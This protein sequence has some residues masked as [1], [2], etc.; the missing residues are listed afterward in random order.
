M[1][2]AFQRAL[3]RYDLA[4]RWD[5]VRSARLYE[6]KG[7][8]FLRPHELSEID[9]E[10]GSRLHNMVA[11]ET[12]YAV[13]SASLRA[14]SRLVRSRPGDIF[15]ELG[16]SFAMYKAFP[17]TLMH[18]HLMRG[19]NE[20]AKN[21]WTGSGY[22]AALMIST[23]LMGA[24]AMNLKEI[25]K[26]RDPRDMSDPKAWAA[27]AMQGGGLGIWGDFFFADA[28]RYGQGWAETFAGPVVG[29]GDDVGRELIVANVQ[30]A[31]SGEETSIASDTVRLLKQY[32]PGSSLW[33]TRVALERA[34]WDQLETWADPRAPRRFADRERK[35]LR[36]F[37]N[38]YWWS[39]GETQ[40]RRAPELAVL[41]N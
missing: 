30:R 22:L 5:E 21:G 3:Q 14:R 10:L 32:T 40:P 7:A 41:T 34:V 17:V 6:H 35:Q 27:A 37:G 25:S 16:R 4:D 36:D 13:P 39:P 29:L 19:V 38:E 33:P 26:G 8:S 18:T 28:T 20:V 23:T 11:T 1:P 15:G 31:L 24:L 12:E 9:P 2:P